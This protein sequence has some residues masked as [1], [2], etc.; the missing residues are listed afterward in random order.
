MHMEGRAHAIEVGRT[1]SHWRKPI[2][3][4]MYSA[5]VC[6]FNSVPIYGVSTLSSM[7]WRLWAN[8]LY[9]IFYPRVNLRPTSWAAF[10]LSL[11]SLLKSLRYRAGRGSNFSLNLPSSRWLHH[12]Y[13]LVELARA[14]KRG[15][16]QFG[17]ALPFSVRETI[18]FTGLISS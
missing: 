6:N 10:Q 2:L 13:S 3:T 17:I 18:T 9:A 12:S 15:V 7:P 4:C 14:T 1:N 11:M 8:L 16:S 5:F